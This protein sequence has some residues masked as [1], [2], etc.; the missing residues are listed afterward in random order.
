MA[1]FSIFQNLQ[2]SARFCK[3]IC[4]F[5]KNFADFWKFCKILQ[6]LPKNVKNFAKISNFLAEICKICSRE[7][8][9]LVDFEKCCKMRIWTRKSASIQPRTSLRKSDVMR[10][11]R[12]RPGLR[13]RRGRLLFPLARQIPPRRWAKR[14]D[15]AGSCNGHDTSLFPK[16]VLGWI[17]ADF[18]NQGLILQHFSRS[19]RKSSSREQ[20]LQIFAKFCEIF[21]KSAS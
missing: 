9:F 11:A 1:F 18:C 8:D 15:H 12:Q 10:I 21:E 2:Y 17:E 20:I 7:D 3:K 14:E 13:R 5:C 16:L 6:N 19:T 4:K